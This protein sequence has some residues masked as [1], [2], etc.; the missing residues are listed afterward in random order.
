[1]VLMH[2]RIRRLVAILNKIGK[3]KTIDLIFFDTGW[4][5]DYSYGQGVQEGLADTFVEPC[6][7]LICERW[8]GVSRN[9]TAGNSIYSAGWAALREKAGIIGEEQ[10]RHFSSDF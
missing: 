5:W 6:L 3:L 1:M 8:V 9:T 2:F 10:F 4:A 7:E